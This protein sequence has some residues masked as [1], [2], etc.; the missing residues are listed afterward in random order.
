MA[1]KLSEIYLYKSGDKHH[2]EMFNTVS[3]KFTD[4]IITKSEAEQISKEYDLDISDI[5][6]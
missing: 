2:L 5:P 4:I 3:G 1:Y 6:F